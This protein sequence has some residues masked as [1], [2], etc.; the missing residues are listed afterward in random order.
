[1]SSAIQTWATSLGCF[2][3]LIIHIYARLFFLS[4]SQG[5]STVLFAAL[6]PKVR[7]QADSVS[8]DQDVRGGG[9]GGRGVGYGG[10]YQGAYLDPGGAFGKCSG[11]AK[12]MELAREMW[13]LTERILAEEGLD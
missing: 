13:E 9:D 1:M 4:A 5:A 11:D 10:G 3:S 2:L 7:F 8:Q 6:S 12:D